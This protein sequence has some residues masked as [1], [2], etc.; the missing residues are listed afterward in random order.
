MLDWIRLLSVKIIVTTKSEV[1]KMG[2]H[3]SCYIFW[4]NR[5][6]FTEIEKNDS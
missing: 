1:I 4:I 5:Y 6:E 2:N 3:V